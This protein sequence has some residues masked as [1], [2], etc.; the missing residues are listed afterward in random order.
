MQIP[1]TVGSYLLHSYLYYICDCSII[2][3]SEYDLLC[4]DLLCAYELVENH[5]HAHLCTKEA[6]SAGTG[7]HIPEWDYPMRI[8]IL[9]LNSRDDE[10]YLQKLRNS[11]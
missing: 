5:E 1:R 2:S 9:A 3:D 11:N 7:H 10:N 8:R 6:L 4:K